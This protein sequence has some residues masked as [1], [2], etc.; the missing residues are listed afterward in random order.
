MKIDVVGVVGAG[1][2]GAGIAQ[3]LA[4]QGIDVILTDVREE[5]LNHAKSIIKKSAEKLAAKG[6]LEKVTP[7]QIL[8]RIECSAVLDAHRRS[9]FVIEAVSES[10]KLKQEIFRS[11]DQITPPTTILTSNTSSISITRLASVTR[12]PDKVAGMHFM[13]PVPIMKLVEGI[14]GLATSNDT[15]SQVREFAERLGKVFVE[16]HDSPGFI[17][18]RVLM[19]LINEAIFAL[20]EG[21]ASAQDIDTAMKLGTNQPMGP[22]TLADFIGLDTCLSI[23]DVM[24]KGFGDPKYRPAPLLKRYVDAGWMGRKTG[25]GFYSYGKE[26]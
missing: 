13:N 14:R 10:E 18:N 23:L 12:R 3:V 8:A 26:E 15:F 20:Q 11:L 5:A 24:Y 19:P 1:Q 6:L 4:Q 16:S 22:L 9:Q 17:V 21:V 25:R 7:E 2:M